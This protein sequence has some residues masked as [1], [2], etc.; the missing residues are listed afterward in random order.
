MSNDAGLQQAVIT[1]LG[2]EPGVTAAHIGVAAKDGVVT[3]SGHV[4]S[5]VE[6]HGAELAARR[7]RGVKAV[8]EEIDVRLPFDAKRGDPELAAAAVDRLA[9]DASL[10]VDAVKVSV[11]QG[12]ITLTGALDWNYQRHAA[13]DDLRRLSG[14]TG[15]TNRITITPKADAKVVSEEIMRA[16]HRSWMT[17]PKTVA[18]SVH[19]GAIRLTGTVR[20]WE[21]WRTASAA[22]WSAPGVLSVENDISIA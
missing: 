1:A 11:E 9:W 6:K 14:V 5:L 16:L 8:V 10:P 2:W 21:E 13:E 12:W 22:A 18:V 15:L 3:L 20:S 17:D 19:G 7:T 4:A